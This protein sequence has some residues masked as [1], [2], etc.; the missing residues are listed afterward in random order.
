MDKKEWKKSKIVLPISL[1]NWYDKCTNISKLRFLFASRTSTLYIV[2]VDLILPSR[3]P[4][5]LVCMACRWMTMV[6]ANI[7]ATTLTPR[8]DRGD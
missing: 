8:D 1:C 2:P 4:T 5:P 7:A 3:R 6:D